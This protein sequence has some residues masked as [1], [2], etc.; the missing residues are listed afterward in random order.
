MAGIADVVHSQ[1]FLV[2][3]LIET[4][5]GILH[6]KVAESS[7]DDHSDE[8]KHSKYEQLAGYFQV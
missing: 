6:C 5:L 7:G 3:E 1:E 2:E 4:V 8:G